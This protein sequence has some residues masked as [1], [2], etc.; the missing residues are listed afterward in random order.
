MKYLIP[1]VIL[2][3]GVLAFVTLKNTK[4]EAEKSERIDRGVLVE[5]ESV[6]K[7]SQKIWIDARGKVIPGRQVTLGAE[8]NGKVRTL[9]KGLNVGAHFKKGEL[10]VK[11][12]AGDY[13]LALEQQLAMVDSAR[14]QLEIE[15]GRKKIAEKEWEI[16]NQGQA[17]NTNSLATREPQIRTARTGLRSAKSSLK[18]AKRTISKTI[19]RAPFDGVVRA[20]AVEIDQI[21]GPGTP[22]L[23]FVGTDNFTVRVSIPLDKLAYIDLPSVDG[24]KQGAPVKVTQIIG[25][26]MKIEKEGRVTRVLSDVDP[27]GRMARILVSIDDPL[28]LARDNGNPLPLLL[29]SFVD[30]AIEGKEIASAF[31]VPR[32]ALREDNTVYV[33]ENGVLAIK[34]V[35]LLWKRR[36]TVLLS[37]GLVGGEKIVVSPLSAAVEGMKLRDNSKTTAP[38]QKEK[39]MS[40]SQSPSQTKKN[41]MP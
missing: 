11:I 32:S 17:E 25:D 12:D 1:L 8:V 34:T 7:G 28:G 35:E 33:Y 27:G 30:I 31:E 38:T 6:S 36:D 10:L 19:L 40:S 37:K 23:T 5:W 24:K 20:K 15:E 13:K 4:P 16:F 39:T 29:E 3:I 21:V 2:V 14:T 9:G 41:A 22:M 26:D 18:Q